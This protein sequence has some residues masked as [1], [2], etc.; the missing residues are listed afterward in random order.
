MT[1]PVIT[2]VLGGDPPAAAMT[3]ITP[4]QSDIPVPLD[5]PVP[6]TY[7]LPPD[8]GTQKFTSSIGAADFTGT[9]EAEVLR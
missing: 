5:N 2:L 6:G 9:L 8:P 4:G 1:F 3:T 7:T